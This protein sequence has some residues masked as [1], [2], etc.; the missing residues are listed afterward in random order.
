VREGGGESKRER[1]QKRRNETKRASDMTNRYYLPMTTHDEFNIMFPSH[2]MSDFPVNVVVGSDE[3]FSDE[4]H[5]FLCGFTFCTCE[6]DFSIKDCSFV[7]VHSLLVD[8]KHRTLDRG[9]GESESGDRKF[10]G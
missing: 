5:I 6:E 7:V 9:D 10:H 1:K 8:A 2:V 3:S 4:V